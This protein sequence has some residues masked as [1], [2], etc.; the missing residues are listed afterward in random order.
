MEEAIRKE[1][2]HLCREIIIDEHQYDTDQL[3]SKTQLMQ[4]KLI[5]LKYFKQRESEMGEEA[6]PVSEEPGIDR[7]IEQTL[8]AAE[9][10][11]REA[12]MKSGASASPIAPQPAEEEPE[13]E[14]SAVSKQTGLNEGKPAPVQEEAPVKAEA[15]QT[16]ATAAETAVEEKPEPTA[17]EPAKPTEAPVEKEEIKED[18]PPQDAPE[19]PQRER[20]KPLEKQQ[21]SL[22]ERFVGNIKLGLNDRIAFVKHLFDGS[23]EDLNRVVSQLN[24][25]NTYPEAADFMENMVKP[26]YDWSEKEE[27]EERFMWHVKQKFGEE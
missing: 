24:T 4:E 1:L 3:I 17:E 2:I 8:E 20:E 18:K 19:A 6:K 25:F 15:R 21:R 7:E 12:E 5:L 10:S 9:S 26:D 13:K 27:Y 16:E 23:Q 22:N 11:R 14:F